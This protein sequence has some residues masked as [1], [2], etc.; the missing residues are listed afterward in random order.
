VVN[1]TYGCC[2]TN[3]YNGRPPVMKK[4]VMLSCSLPALHRLDDLV[5][6]SLHL[7]VIG[8]NVPLG[9]G[10]PGMAHQLLY[11]GDGYVGRHQVVGECVA[12]LVGG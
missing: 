6:V 1:E 4:R 7:A 3:V 9:G 2:V 8:G 10:Y 12:Q 11:T 5:K